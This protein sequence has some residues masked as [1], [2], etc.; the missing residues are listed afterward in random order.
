MHPHI[1][2]VPCITYPIHLILQEIPIS[3]NAQGIARRQ[4]LKADMDAFTRIISSPF[5]QEQHMR[6]LLIALLISQ[7]FL[8][9]SSATPASA[10][11]TMS[12]AEIRSMPID[13][14]PYRAGH[15][16]G[17]TVRRRGHRGR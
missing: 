5:D 1:R 7:A 10:R 2:Q 11:T 8:L 9:S 3:T 14:R 15:F 12:R 17:N 13:S 4:L 16:Y 6:N